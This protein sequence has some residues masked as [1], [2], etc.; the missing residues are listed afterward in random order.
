[1][2]IKLVAILLEICNFYGLI[3]VNSIAVFSFYESATMDLL[4]HHKPYL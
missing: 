4:L 3:E 1:M 2:F